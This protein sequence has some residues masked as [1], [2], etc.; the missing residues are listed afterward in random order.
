VVD[1]TSREAGGKGVNVSRALNSVGRENTALVV[2]GDENGDEFI[3]M[4]TNDSLSCAPVFVSGRIRE[5]ITLHESKNP[6]T[7]ISF[8]GFPIGASVLER[9]SEA[10]FGSDS[11]TVITMTGSIP[12]GIEARDVLDMLGKA[13]A[14]GAKIVIDSR[15]VSLPEII[16]FSPWLIKP[17]EDE[18]EKYVGEKISAP[19]DAARIAERL[20]ALGIENV[21]ISLGADGAVLT[22]PEGS[23]YAK[24]PEISAVSTIGAGDSSI[25]GFIDAFCSGASSADRLRRAVSF[26]TAACMRE[27]TKPPLAEDI[28]CV[29]KRVFVE[30]I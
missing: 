18:I 7:R 15:S 5:N 30:K 14:K 2:V 28:T 9:I 19:E 1:I 3:K 22:S 13:R 24:A 12:K 11:E 20:Q 23:F 25:A 8:G 27:G 21:M 6:E 29:S 26:G 16:S 4:L 10:L 17:N